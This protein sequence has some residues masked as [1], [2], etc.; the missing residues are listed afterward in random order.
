VNKEFQKPEWLRPF[1]AVLL[2][3][4]IFTAGGAGGYLY[5][6]NQY[7]LEKSAI[8]ERI[9]GLENQVKKVSNKTLTDV[10]DTQATTE[11]VTIDWKTYT[12]EYEGISVKY[13]STWTL[14]LKNETAATYN[15]SGWK[16]PFDG[17]TLTPKED[18]NFKIEYRTHIEGLGGGCDAGVNCP[19]GFFYEVSPLVG[20]GLND[21][22]MIKLEQRE[23]DNKTVTRR[24]MFLWNPS[25]SSMSIPKTGSSIEGLFYGLYKSNGNDGGLSQLSASFVDQ[26]SNL[27]LS[28]EDYYNLPNIKEAVSILKTVKF[29]K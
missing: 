5:L 26:Q 3:I 4:L 12:G 18:G 21:L 23:Q 6:A 19:R 25:L 27:S 24:S 9:E 8:E 7:D 10:S 28:T 11:D 1:L 15:G 29:S 13:P 17:F 14:S 20:T 2:F 22:Q 16:G